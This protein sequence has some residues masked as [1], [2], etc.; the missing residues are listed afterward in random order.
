MKLFNTSV[1]RL[2]PSHL[3]FTK[4]NASQI[5]PFIKAIF[6]CEGKSNGTRK[7]GVIVLVIVFQKLIGS[8]LARGSTVLLRLDRLRKTKLRPGRLLNVFGRFHLSIVSRGFR[9]LTH[10]GSKKTTT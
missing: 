6:F 8:N 1:E 5:M 4:A 10:R 3:A 9:N 7:S 2:D